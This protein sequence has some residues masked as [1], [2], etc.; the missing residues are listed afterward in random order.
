L[1]LSAGGLYGQRYSFKYYGQDEGLSNLNIRALLQDQTGFLWVG[2]DNGLFRYDGR[3]FR[4]FG[5]ADGLPSMQVYALAETADGTLW[6]GSITGVARRVGDR[7]EKLDLR[8]AKG[9]RTIM[10][11]RRNRLFITTERGLLFAQLDGRSPPEF[12]LYP[13][14]GTP[15]PAQ[16]I[17]VDAA[18]KVWYG[19][20]RSICTF[21]GA[22]VVS[23]AD[24]GVP[25]DEYTAIVVDGSG[26]IWARSLSRLVELPAG[27]RRFVVQG[28]E[29]AAAV[30][31]A[32]LYMDR[33]GELL[34]PTAL[35][36]GRRKSDGSW[37][38]IRKAN[39]LPGNNISSVMED[40]EGSL[41]IGIGGV[42]LVRWLGRGR[43][44]GWTEAE[45]LSHD[46]IWSIQRDAAGTLWAATEDGLSRFDKS[47]GCWQPWRDAALKTGR[48]LA[49]AS[50]PNGNLWV[51]QNPGGVIE[52]DAHSHRAVAYGPA[53][54][55]TSSRELALAMN[56]SGQLWAG[57]M[58]GLFEGIRTPAGMRFRHITLNQEGGTTVAAIACDRQGRV[59]VTSGYGVFVRQSGG[60]RHITTADGLRHNGT[61]YIGEGPDGS[62]WIAYREPLGV[63]RIFLEGDRAR[64]RNF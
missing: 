53:Q 22:R 42:G 50:A 14:P 26:N 12:K 15:A 41:W 40:R 63:A 10:A 57:S 25:P 24:W 58:D 64:V 60:W 7:F 54:G 38:I 47:R 33:Q 13:H 35:G 43:W 56:M 46:T 34:V 29:L 31:I 55:L 17:A 6:V 39:G 9:T 48:T 61:M 19:C 28:R 36:L 52:I 23:L 16:G 51:G 49:L 37:E 4:M 59:W 8:L 2:T 62:M 18:G 1:I 5:T 3:H 11:D 44:E 45:G 32:R 20:G 30:R 27:S 21:D